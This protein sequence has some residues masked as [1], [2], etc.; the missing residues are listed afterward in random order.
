M[1]RL[2][3]CSSPRIS[4]LY[5][6]VTLMFWTIK[7]LATKSWWHLLNT[8]GRRSCKMMVIKMAKTN[9]FWL[10]PTHCVPNIRQLILTLS[11]SW[12]EIHFIFSINLVMKHYFELFQTKVMAV[13][14]VEE[15][16]NSR[17]MNFP[18]RIIGNGIINNTLTFP[19]SNEWNVMITEKYISIIEVFMIIWV[20]LLQSDK[21]QS[22]PVMKHSWM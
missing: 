20:F 6:L 4:R 19:S 3:I 14:Q 13:L 17:E 9:I 8:G 22:H 1:T 2:V 7:M 12:L 21:T 5:I 16:Q 18:S 10:S 15:I 11:F